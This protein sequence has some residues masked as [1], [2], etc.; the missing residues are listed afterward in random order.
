MKLKVVFA[1]NIQ[2]STIL[3]PSTAQLSILNVKN[4]NYSVISWISRKP[5]IIY[6]ELGYGKSY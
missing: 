5:S 2:Q 4:E 1:K 3:W 6:G